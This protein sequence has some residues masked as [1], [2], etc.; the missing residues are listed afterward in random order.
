MELESAALTGETTEWSIGGAVPVTVLSAGESVAVEARPR[1]VLEER[2]GGAHCE[3]FQRDRIL[4]LHLSTVLSIAHNNDK[5]PQNHSAS[6]A[7]ALLL[8]PWLS[9]P[10]PV[11]PGV[12]GHML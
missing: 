7:S 5:S 6:V 1:Q 11:L 9:F 2:C 10:V 3:I 4:L 12:K 8:H